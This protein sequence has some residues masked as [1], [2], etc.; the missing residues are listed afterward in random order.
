MATNYEE[1]S[2]P[3]PELEGILVTE[4]GGEFSPLFNAPITRF[5]VPPLVE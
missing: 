1:G 3:M 5:A 2:G 4:E